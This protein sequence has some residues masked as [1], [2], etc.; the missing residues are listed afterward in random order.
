MFAELPELSLKY[1]NDQVKFTTQTPFH[2]V[3]MCNQKQTSKWCD[4]STRRSASEGSHIWDA[5]YLDVM[6]KSAKLLIY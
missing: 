2:S 5:F 4:C 3:F 6:L 1:I